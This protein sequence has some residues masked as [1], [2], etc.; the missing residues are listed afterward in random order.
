MFYMLSPRVLHMIFD[1]FMALVLSHLI[2]TCSKDKSKSL[3]VCFIQRIGA[4]YKL[5]AM[6]SA[7]TIDKATEF[8]FLLCNETSECPR[9]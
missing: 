4:Q 6:Y 8:Y 9:K 7:S 5:D 2:R 3:S 1:I